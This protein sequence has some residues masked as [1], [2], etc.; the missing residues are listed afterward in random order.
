[1]KNKYILICSI[2]FTFLLGS[3]K[4]EFLEVDS[5]SSV[6]I[7]DYYT[8]EERIFEALVAAYDPLAWTDYAWGQFTQLNLVSDVMSDDVYVGGNDQGDQPF[9]HKMFNYEATPE[10]VCSDLWTTFYSG[11][12]RA[13][14]VLEYMDDVEDISDETKALYLAEAK[15]L[16]SYYY[17]WLW[18]LW[19]NIP[20]YEVNLDFPYT[21]PQLTADE[22]YNGIITTLEDAIDNGG[23]AIKTT[24]ENTG[25]VS[26]AFAYMIYAEVVMYQNDESKY[27]T[28]L[29][30]MNEIISSNQYSLNSD[31]A[32]IWEASGEWTE[33]SIFEVNYFSVN[34]GKD[35]GAAIEDG[36]TVYPKLIGINNLSG[37][38]DFDGGWGFEPV[39]QEI[40]DLYEDMDQRKNGGI[41][42]MVSYA[43]QTGA[44]YEG[45]YQDTGNF[46]KKYLPR[47][48]GNA[49]YSGS[50]DMNYNNNLRVY[51]YS[52]TLLNAAELLANG[53]SGTGSAQTYLD[54]VRTRA[55]VASVSATVDN[56]IA[57]RRLEFVGEGKRYWDL[58]R[59]G[60]AATTLV[61]NEYRTTTWT[62]NKKY[63]P[64]PQSEMD[65]DSGLD[66]NPY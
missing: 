57:E 33:E 15:V 30:Y 41:L 14:A 46:L 64:I 8:T 6:L 56:I 48:N 28:A 32:N 23:L 53:T 2:F 54:E 7:D 35:W 21:T 38:P 40:Y 9:L 16:R 51:R 31:F 45:R 17:M 66:Q 44:T 60:K 18:K 55:G 42:N 37:S 13:N 52:E 50:P 3:C 1:M 59:S 61:P 27:S 24:S 63:L 62:E 58:I 5:A 22:V 4:E 47:T 34:G 65:S 10:I 12:K 11:V 26:L 25:R 20:Y 19:G 29:A 43:A 36:G 39:R 49:D